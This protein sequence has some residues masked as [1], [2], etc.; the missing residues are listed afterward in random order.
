MASESNQYSGYML[1][2]NKNDNTEAELGQASRNA[3]SAK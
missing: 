2:E 3:W 1:A